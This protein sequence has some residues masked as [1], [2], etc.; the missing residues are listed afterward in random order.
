SADAGEGSSPSSARPRAGAEGGK[1]RALWAA[2]TT[3]ANARGTWVRSSRSGLRPGSSIRPRLRVGPS[4]LVG[5]RTPT[6][7]ASKFALLATAARV[8]L[9]CPADLSS[10]SPPRDPPRPHAGLRR[11]RRCERGCSGCC[12][13]RTRLGAARRLEAVVVEVQNSFRYSRGA[14]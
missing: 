6:W 3:A 13:L 8:A 4:R 7:R 10:L 12:V 9:A 1:G 11:W 2:A 14:T 5:A